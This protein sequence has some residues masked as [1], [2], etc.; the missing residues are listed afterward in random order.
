MRSASDADL[1]VYEA[2]AAAYD[3]LRSQALFE[4]RWLARFTASLKPGEYARLLEE[5][6]LRLTGFLAEDPE[7]DRHTVLVAR[8]DATD[9][10]EDKTEETAPCP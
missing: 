5:A 6:G 10:T 2:Q 8:R 7:T 9:Q 3:R 4:A 1:D